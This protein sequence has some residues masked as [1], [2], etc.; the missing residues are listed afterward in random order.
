MLKAIRSV[1]VTM[2]LVV[3]ITGCQQASLG[4]IEYTNWLED[5]AH[6]LRQSV[7]H[8]DFDFQIQYKSLPY[9]IAK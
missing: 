3:S 2:L 5:E 4:P 7:S 1:V 9:I 8:G 6:N